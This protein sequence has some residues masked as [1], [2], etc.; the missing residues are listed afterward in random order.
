L[1]LNDVTGCALSEAIEEQI[2][3]Q[4]MKKELSHTCSRRERISSVYDDLD[5]MFFVAAVI[6]LMIQ[7][8]QEKERQHITRSSGRL[9]QDA[10]I[11]IITSTV[12]LTFWIRKALTLNTHAGT[13]RWS[14]KERSKGE[15]QLC[16]CIFC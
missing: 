6:F 12:P 5:Q 10:N 15:M 7:N 2:L 8:K 9:R 4:N 1:N 14:T 16:N 11:L 13:S 3:K